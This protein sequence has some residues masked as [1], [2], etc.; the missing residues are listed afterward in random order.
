MTKYVVFG[1]EKKATKSFPIDLLT[2]WIINQSRGFTKRIVGE[3]HVFQNTFKVLIHKDY[4]V[5]TGIDRYQ[6]IIE[7]AQIS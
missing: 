3:Q 5:G 4:S 2:H 1:D 6:R 7:N